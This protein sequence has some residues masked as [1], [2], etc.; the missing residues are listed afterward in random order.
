MQ[1]RFPSLILLGI[2]LAALPA[3]GHHAPS[4]YDLSA[5]RTLTGS[6]LAFD[7]V[8]PHTMTTI[9]VNAGNG[10]A[11]EWRLEGMHPDFLGR[12]GWTRHTLAPGDRIEV[13]YFPRRDGSRAGMLVRATLPDGTV[14]V[15]ATTS[16]GGA[17]TG[18]ARD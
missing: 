9:R 12:R 11:T 1:R 6:V 8:A 10:T 3:A 5:E 18:A 2:G 4:L 14:K 13:V 16:P 17:G 15:M 7:W